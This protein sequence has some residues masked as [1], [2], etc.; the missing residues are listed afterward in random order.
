MVFMYNLC[1]PLLCFLPS[2][3]APLELERWVEVLN[4]GDK[5]SILISS[6]VVLSHL[7]TSIPLAARPWVKAK[8]L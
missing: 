6:H 7:E 2:F 4:H 5:E 8:Y 3:L 1:N